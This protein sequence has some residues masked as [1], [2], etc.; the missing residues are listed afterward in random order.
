MI[1][2]Q[3]GRFVPSVRRHDG[4]ATGKTRLRLVDVSST[5]YSIALGHRPLRRDDFED[6]HELAKLAATAGLSVEEFRRAFEYLVATE[7]PP[8]SFDVAP[9]TRARE[10][11]HP[12]G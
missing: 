10:G 6:A 12:H 11:A 8:V 1:S 9:D 2:I 3:A 4:S 5:R 7:P